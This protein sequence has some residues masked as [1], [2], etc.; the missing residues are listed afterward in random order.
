[1]AIAALEVDDGFVAA[2]LA[3]SSKLCAPGRSG[4]NETFSARELGEDGL[5]TAR[6]AGTSNTVEI[7]CA[8]STS[9]VLGEVA[10]AGGDAT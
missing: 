4:D 1:M 8:V 2:V 3:A 6:L 5:V 7:K 10:C 9:G